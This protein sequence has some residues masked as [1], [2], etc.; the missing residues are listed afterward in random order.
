MFLG[1][2]I[3]GRWAGSR[4]VR[5]YLRASARRCRRPCWQALGF[6][7][8]WRTESAAIGLG[9]LFLTGLGIASLYPLLLS[10]AIASA[11]DKTVE[12]SSRATLASGAAILTLPLVLGRLADAVGIQL[13]YIVVLRAARGRLR[14]QL[15]GRADR[16]WSGKPR[17]PDDQRLDAIRCP[18]LRSAGYLATRMPIQHKSILRKTFNP[19]SAYTR[20][21]TTFACM[22]NCR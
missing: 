6:L 17:T 2:M 7:V 19:S 5:R 16:L 13:A 12:A 22:N 10:L 11:K 15:G 3:V 1:A 14:R 9:G 4:L 8:F 20:S 18:A 21:L